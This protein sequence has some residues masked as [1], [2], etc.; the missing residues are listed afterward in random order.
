[1]GTILARAK[2][3][4]TMTYTAMVR[5]KRSGAVVFSK[6]ATFDREPAAKAWI[7]K[8]EKAAAQP[9][10]LEVKIPSMTLDAAIQRYLD[11]SRKAIGKT[12]AQVLEA[13]RRDKI[14]GMACEAISSSDI[15][16]YATRLGDGRQPQTVMNYL[17]HL[18][19]VFAVAE[20]AFGVPLDDRAMRDALKACKRLGLVSKSTE[21]T[22]R[23]TIEELDKLLEA[24]GRRSMR[25]G[26]PPMMHVTAFAIYSTRRQEEITRLRWADLEPGRILVR[27]MKN[28]G[29]KMGNHVWCDLVPEAEEII[30]SMPRTGDLIF[31]YDG[32]AI[33]AAFARTC[34]VLGIEDLHFHDLRHEG[35]S[36]LFEMGWTIPQVASVTGHRSWSSLQRYTHL[37]QTGDKLAAWKWREALSISC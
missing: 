21:R 30:A 10:G 14:A 35:A 28:P 15:V 36:R 31:P 34:Q 4:G 20:S 22:R 12:K 16:S 29:E 11:T 17:S 33:S 27:D 5:I 19:A 32:R 9:G 1:M 26:S 24:F 18:G 25:A 37:R 8:T 2:Q 23:P 6:S 13:I 7:K 3:D